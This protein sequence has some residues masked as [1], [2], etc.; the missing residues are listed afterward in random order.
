MKISTLTE[1]YHCQMLEA[2]H[3]Q[4]LELTTVQNGTSYLRQ[5]NL[6]GSFCAT[7]NDLQV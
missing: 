6:N 5:H 1:P 4:K 2:R 7:V 3:R